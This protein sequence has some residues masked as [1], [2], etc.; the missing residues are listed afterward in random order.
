MKKRNDVLPPIEE[1]EDYESIRKNEA[2][3][4]ENKTRP[5]LPYKGRKRMGTDNPLFK[6]GKFKP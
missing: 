5:S 2:I 6:N 4:L 3:I 1:V